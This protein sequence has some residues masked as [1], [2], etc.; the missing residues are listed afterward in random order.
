MSRFGRP[1]IDTCCK[2]EELGAKLK[3]PHLSDNVKRAVACELIVHKRRSKKFYKKLEEITELSKKRNDILAIAFDFM[4]Q[5]TD[6]QQTYSDP[7]QS[8]RRIPIPSEK[9]EDIKK[10]ISY[11]PHEYLD[12]YND[13]TTW[14]TE[15]R[16]SRLDQEES[17]G[18]E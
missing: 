3:S 5:R 4:Q 2:C 17:V 8:T 10:S 6:T 12:F 13:I 7:H 9:M 18:D 16:R 15:E 1:Q 11:I 14:P